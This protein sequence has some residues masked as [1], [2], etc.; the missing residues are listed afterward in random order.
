MDF[1]KEYMEKHGY[2]KYE[3]LKVSLLPKLWLAYIADPE[4]SGK[5]HST[6]KQR[7]LNGEPEVR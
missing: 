2:G 6:V 4:D 3:R 1:N 5:V 7:F